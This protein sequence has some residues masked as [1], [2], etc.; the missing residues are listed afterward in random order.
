[1]GNDVRWDRI[2]AARE[3]I[4]RGDYDNEQVLR[5]AADRLLEGLTGGDGHPRADGRGHDQAN[6][7]RA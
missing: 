2:Q 6:E 1:M 7:G 3:K 4:A 5:Y